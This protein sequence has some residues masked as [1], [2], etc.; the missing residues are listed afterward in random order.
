MT[1]ICPKCGKKM[2][3]HIVACWYC[4]E[5]L[6]PGLRRICGKESLEK[7]M[8]SGRNPTFLDREQKIPKRRKE[9]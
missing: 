1:M 8:K 4:G 2:P 3:D 6:S 9:K 5:P 7:A